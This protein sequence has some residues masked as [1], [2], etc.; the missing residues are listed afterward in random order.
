MTGSIKFF[1]AAKGFGFITSD[2][3]DRDVFVHKSGL[4]RSYQKPQ[5]DERVQFEIS[6]G[7]KGPQ[8]VNVDRMN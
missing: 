1:N 5:K 4:S 8:A 6:E 3:S 2:D 7:K